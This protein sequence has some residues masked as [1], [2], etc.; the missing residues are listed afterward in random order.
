MIMQHTF[1]IIVVAL[2]A[3]ANAA[4]PFLEEPDT[5]LDR[6]VGDLAVGAL[7]NLTDM[8]CLHD[9]DWA[10]Q[11]Y[12]PALNYTYYRQAAGGEGSYRNN[13]EVFA[14][15][16]FIPR[17]MQD[18]TTLNSTLP[19]VTMAALTSILGYNFSVPFF[20]APASRA[21]YGHPK[22]EAGLVEA[23]GREGI[24]YARSQFAT[25]SI[26]EVHALKM[27][28]QVLFQQFYRAPTLE[29]DQANLDE[30]AKVGAQAI[31]LT[32][33]TQSYGSRIRGLR[34]G[35]DIT[36]NRGYRN[37]TW[38]YYK[39]L[40][41]MTKLP[42]VLKG[43]TN[44]Y[45]ARTAVANGVPAIY[46]SNHGGRQLETSPSALEVAHE[47]YLQAP[48]IFRQIEVY[49]DGG[50]RY[51]SDILKLLAFGVRAVGL[52][53][54]FMFANVFGVD[55]VQRAIKLLKNEVSRDAAN[56]GLA[57]LKALNTSWIQTVQSAW[58]GFP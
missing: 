16:R 48:E 57:D 42:I 56:L 1:G 3:A 40:C 36:E 38:D 37:T 52:G 24:L 32:V 35:F 8:V 30:I 27:P 10:A 2:V 39:T 9:F 46:L 29:E 44:V 49:A 20:I 15:Y 51:G 6:T 45:E 21:A 25:L 4:R 22:A 12:L 11:N 54:P 34:Y 28:G 55:G 53:R 23:A 7:P 26:E 33:D 13:L 41:N 14:N 50:V 43:I 5:G 31:M 18:V 17:Q 19:C 47:I 58:V